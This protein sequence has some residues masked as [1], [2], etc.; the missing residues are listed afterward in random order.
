MQKAVRGLVAEGI[1][2]AKPGAGLRVLATEPDRKTRSAACLPRPP[3]ATERHNA[4]SARE[5]I[6]DTV[7]RDILHGHFAVGSPLPLLKEL[8]QRY[9]GCAVTLR[10][11]LDHLMREGL[12]EPFGRGYRTSGMARLAERNIVALLV[13]PHGTP[14]STAISEIAR[15]LNVDAA[16]A[17][18]QLLAVPFSYRRFGANARRHVAHRLEHEGA[19]SRLLGIMG[20]ITADHQPSFEILL[21]YL[22]SLGVPVAFADD[23]GE[24]PY[25]TTAHEPRLA[26][27]SAGATQRCGEM[28]GRYLVAA[29][30]RDVAY[31]T[32]DPNTA[33][34]RNRFAGLERLMVQ[35]G[36]TVCLVGPPTHVTR[37][38]LRQSLW[39]KT[40]P[41]VNTIFQSGQLCE[42]LPPRTVSDIEHAFRVALYSRLHYHAAFTLL[43]PILTRSL[44]RRNVTA[45]V[46]ENDMV[47]AACL[48]FLREHH[49]HGP[50]GMCVVGFDDS[51]EAAENDLT[52]Y[53]FNGPGIARAMLQFV[54]HPR[55]ARRTFPGSP[56][57]I[58]GFVVERGSA[59]SRFCPRKD[60]AAESR[61]DIT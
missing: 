50:A 17:G 55:Q 39:A 40:W 58:D 30:H 2:S 37:T 3:R 54:L 27:F 46:A 13:P 41:S 20:W 48:E 60:R 34:S 5:R 11:V 52:S 36:G 25:A 16:T 19:L 29:G 26:W 23:S 18:V 51:P 6:L 49:M 53:N 28:V 35:S 4:T 14:V 32:L 9:G 44:A 8:T 59:P 31:V 56:V 45:W 61:L 21:P 22:R 43:R 33:Y 1:L 42:H 10:S 38:T 12:L 47:A 24:A 7:R 15:S 57:D